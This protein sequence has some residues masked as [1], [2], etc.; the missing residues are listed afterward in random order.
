MNEKNGWE[1]EREGGRKSLSG[2]M[3]RKEH[4][5]SKLEDPIYAAAL[6]FLH[7]TDL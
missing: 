3:S 5:T 1:K 6:H 2:N 7:V 4:E